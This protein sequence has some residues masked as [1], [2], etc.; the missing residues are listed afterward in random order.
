[1]AEDPVCGMEVDE[2]KAAATCVYKGQTLYFCAEACKRAFQ[3]DPE[4]YTRD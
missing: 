3:K 4:K 2:R 1:M